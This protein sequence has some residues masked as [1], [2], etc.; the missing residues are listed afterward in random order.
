MG[1]QGGGG[2]GV[3]GNGGGGMFAYGRRFILQRRA[4]AGQDQ[5]Q[6]HTS[7]NTMLRVYPGEGQQRPAEQAIQPDRQR[8][9]RDQNGP[10]RDRRQANSTTICA[11]ECG[12]DTSGSAF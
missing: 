5:R 8:I 4:E 6:R 2:R 7:G 9:G 10:G 1:S 3:P 11:T 12:R